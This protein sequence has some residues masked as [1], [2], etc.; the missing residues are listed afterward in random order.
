MPIVQVEMNTI[1]TFLGMLCATVQGTTGFFA[2][3]VRKRG[4]L[5]KTNDTLHRAHTAFGTFATT[6]YFLGLFAGI[7]GLVGAI[8]RNEPP[9]ELQSPSFNVH[10]WGSF[11]VLAIVLWK[12]YMSYF[13]KKPLYAKKK[14][15]GIA[16]F[17]AWT[18]NWLT[19]ANSYYVRTL[20][21]NP[22][23]PPPVFLL[24][25]ELMWLQLALPFLLGGVIG[26]LILRRFV[27]EERG[28]AAKR[29]SRPA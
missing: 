13:R 16:M 2:A 11:V 5:L 23:H 24:P 22:Q 15:L 28:E 12:T 9:L 4:A 7:N 25:Y 17:F 14:W 20:P 1:I 18:Y 3:Y 29:S 21:S 10:T 26:W 27:R 6:L 19:A 8:T